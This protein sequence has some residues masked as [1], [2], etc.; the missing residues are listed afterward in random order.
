[1]ME[2]HGGMERHRQWQITMVGMASTVTKLN[3]MRQRLYGWL[4]WNS[5][6]ELKGTTATINQA[7][8]WR[9]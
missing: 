7:R 8:E 2:W 3:L 1:M 4:T 5:I 6:I 9:H